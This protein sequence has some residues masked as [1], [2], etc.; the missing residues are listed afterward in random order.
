MAA[1]AEHAAVLVVLLGLSSVAQ[2]PFAPASAAAIPNVVPEADVPSANA[3]VA[4]TSS[5]G[6]LLGPLL[7]GA[8]LGVGASPAAVFVV[9]AGTFVFSAVLVAA[10]RRPFGRGSTEEYPGALVGLRVIVREPALR[11]PV[12]AGMVSLVG[13]GIVD[14]ASYPLSLDLDGGTPGY[15]A[16]VALLGGGGLLGAALAGRALRGDPARVLV[17]GFGAGAA[18]LAVAGAAPALA[19]GIAG[20]A[21]AG[22]GRGLGDVAAVTLIQTR[23]ADEVR[24]RVFAAQDGAAHAA[25]SVSAFSGGVL[26]ELVGARGAFATAAA[27]GVGAALIAGRTPATRL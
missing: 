7:G 10:I 5:A 22:A 2:A 25:F 20:M 16:M 6:Y 27:I 26:V 3:L 11:L 15:G 19:I 23:A 4:A 14:V 17:V 18:G 1:A 21:L 9:D 12:L 24:S 8:L 13:I